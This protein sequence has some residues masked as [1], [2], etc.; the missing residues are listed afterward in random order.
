MRGVGPLLAKKRSRDALGRYLYDL[1]TCVSYYSYLVH[2][3]YHPHLYLMDLALV[4][5]MINECAL[6]NNKLKNLTLKI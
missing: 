3:H 6:M 4:R 1:P 5:R 2:L